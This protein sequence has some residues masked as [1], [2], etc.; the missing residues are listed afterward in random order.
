M[1]SGGLMSE[2]PTIP[3][4]RR[5]KGD[6][7]DRT[8]GRLLQAAMELIRAKGFEKTTLAEVAERAG[9]TTGSIY[10]NFKNRDELF[11]AVAEIKGA[12]IA[13]RM[14][15]GMTFADLMG[16]T[17]EAVITAIPQ[18]RSAILGALSFH[19]Y[20]LTHEELRSRVLEA[21]AQ[22]YRG[23]AASLALFPQEELPMAPDILVPVLHALTDGLLLQR[24]MTPEFVTDEVIHAA[25]AA[26]AHGRSDGAG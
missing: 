5:P 11:M 13:P 8:K 23:A 18:R 6:K 21:T 24:F 7:R 10:G 2:T 1:K 14:W 22:I 15:P 16:T 19:S 9:V 3:S 4:R 12:P 25:F 20:A 17:A 26:L